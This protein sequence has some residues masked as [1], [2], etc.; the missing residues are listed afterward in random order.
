MD[1]R[2]FIDNLATQAEENPVLAIAAAAALIGSVSKLVN[3]MAWKKEVA[4]RAMKDRS[5]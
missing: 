1:N 5:K 2:R 3:S 4:R